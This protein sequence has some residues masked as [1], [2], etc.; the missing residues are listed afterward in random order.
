MKDAK[1][2][3][4]CVRNRTAHIRAPGVISRGIRG[5]AV[6]VVE[7]FKNAFR[8]ALRT[9]FTVKNATSIAVFY[10]NL[11]AAANETGR[12]RKKETKSKNN[13]MQ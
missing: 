12:L 7:V 9:I 6:P 3:S 13:R 5:D 4:I 10:P 2:I 1:T 8:T 11:K